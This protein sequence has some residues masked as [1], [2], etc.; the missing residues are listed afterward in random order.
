MAIFTP[1]IGTIVGR[2]NP[3]QR[4]GLNFIQAGLGAG[5]SGN[6]IMR[7]LRGTG[8]GIGRADTQSLIRYYQGRELGRN[9]YRF[10]RLNSVP[11]PDRMSISAFNI[12]RKYHYV[13]GYDFVDPKTGMT[14]MKFM[15]I[16][17]SN[18]MKF[19]T[20]LDKAMEIIDDRPENYPQIVGE[21]FIED[22]VKRD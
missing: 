9:R 8:M 2:L 21:V 6:A 12:K 17:T 20:A 18:L 15:T 14:Q 5:L 22:V 3:L 10:A 19:E 11:N 7:K 4:L 13:V 1:N 16:E